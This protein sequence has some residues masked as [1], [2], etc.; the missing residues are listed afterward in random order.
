[1]FPRD[2][3]GTDDDRSRILADPFQE[4]HVGS[5]RES[6]RVFAESFVQVS[7]DQGADR[8]PADVR[9]HAV[10]PASAGTGIRYLPVD[11]DSRGDD[12]SL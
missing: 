9:E 2:K 8:M 3:V 10:E 5:D 6:P 7:P 11:A 12:V 1:M 4:M